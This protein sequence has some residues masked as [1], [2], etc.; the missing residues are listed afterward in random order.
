MR[1]A[2][3]INNT[4]PWIAEVNKGCGA[5]AARFPNK[6][7]EYCDISIVA[8]LCSDGWVALGGRRVLVG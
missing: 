3:P 2:P 1:Y 6:L 7:T 8:A 4:F 5:N